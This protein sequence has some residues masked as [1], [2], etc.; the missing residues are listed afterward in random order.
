MERDL[1]E[2][3]QQ[4]SQRDPSLSLFITLGIINGMKVLSRLS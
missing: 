3:T 2:Y 4:E 1:F